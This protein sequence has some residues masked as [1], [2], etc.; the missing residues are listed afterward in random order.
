MDGWW[1]Y[2]RNGM[3]LQLCPWYLWTRTE[4]DGRSACCIQDD[5]R[6]FSP[7]TTHKLP[8]CGLH[9]SNQMQTNCP[10]LNQAPQKKKKSSRHSRDSKKRK[11]VSGAWVAVPTIQRR[12][13]IK[14]STATPN[15]SSLC[16]VV[17]RKRLNAYVARAA[18]SSRSHKS[19]SEKMLGLCC[20]NW[21][22]GD[23]PRLPLTF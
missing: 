1:S 10:G 11:S 19:R 7:L 6:T 13:P 17:Q 3:S 2:Q 9:K 22:S 15:N 12:S 20:L 4:R 8:A 18:R 14:S 23:S 16:Q 5:P 21:I